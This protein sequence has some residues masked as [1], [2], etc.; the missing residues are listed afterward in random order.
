MSTDEI[1]NE[2]HRVWARDFKDLERYGPPHKFSPRRLTG[3]YAVAS[4]CYYG[5]D[6]S[7]ISDQMFDKLC[8]WLLDNHKKCEG[9]GADMLDV[10]LLSCSS[11]VDVKKFVRPYHDIAAILLGHPCRCISCN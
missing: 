3:L 10:G 5:N 1:H 6:H 4:I 2:A 11:G 9:E 8:R 7:P